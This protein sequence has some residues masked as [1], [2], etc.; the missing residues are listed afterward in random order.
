MDIANHGAAVDIAWVAR[1]G[2]TYRVR[3]ANTPAEDFTN[4]LAT[5]TAGGPASAPWY[6]VTNTFTDT[7]LPATRVYVVEVQP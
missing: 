4:V 3:S 6:M 1:A 5:V 2:K 7:T